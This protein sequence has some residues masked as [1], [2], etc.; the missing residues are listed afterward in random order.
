MRRILSND[1]LGAARAGHHA[2]VERVAQTLEH[3]DNDRFRPKKVVKRR[4][5]SANNDRI[6]NQR[7]ATKR[8]KAKI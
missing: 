8:A 3:E 6:P 1:R 7:R 2:I 5:F 4:I